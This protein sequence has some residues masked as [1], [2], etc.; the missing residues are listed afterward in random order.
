MKRTMFEKGL[1]LHKEFCAANK[2]KPPTVVE[3]DIAKRFGT[4]AFYRPH[5]ITICVNAC[6]HIGTAAQAWS[7]PGYVIDRTPYGV[8]QHE[9]GHAA[10]HGLANRGKADRYFSDFSVNLRAASGED[11]LT[12]YCPNDAEWF[13][14]MFRLFVTNSDLL[15]RV[16]PRTYA[17]LREHFKPVVDAPWTRV[18]KGAPERTLAQAAKKIEAAK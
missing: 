15:K 18:L 12:N 11:K 14:E 7:F 13:A 4:C 6:A 16:R 17:L 5:Q 8:I 10:D 3:N 1:E 9:Q 2:L